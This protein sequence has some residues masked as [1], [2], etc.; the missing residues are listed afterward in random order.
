MGRR[1]GEVLEVIVHRFDDSVAIERALAPK[2]DEWLRDG[3]YE[4]RDATES[5]QISGIDR[6]VTVDDDNDT[7]VGIDYKCDTRWRHTG[8]LFIETVSNDRTGAPG[9]AVKQSAAKWILYF[10][11][12]SQVFV[13]RARALREAVGRWKAARL[14]ERK[15]ENVGYSTVGL[16]VPM[17][18]AEAFTEYVA[19]L[20]R[21]DGAVL[22]T[23]HAESGK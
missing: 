17:A 14:P 13:Y 20:D 9:W 15:A 10:T 23:R 18:A 16:C 19:R 21:G 1:D 11:A 12:P 3:G 6:V 8:N 22:M 5:E 7:H 2:L 4:L